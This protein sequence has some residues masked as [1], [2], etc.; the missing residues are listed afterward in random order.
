V[1]LFP[2]VIVYPKDR[3]VG[4]NGFKNLLCLSQKGMVISVKIIEREAFHICGYAIETNAEQNERDSSQ[5]Y[6][7]FFES[8]SVD[9]DYGMWNIG[10]GHGAAQNVV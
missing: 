8:D 6:K 5:L 3:S 4:K 9:G 7:D 2:Q 1:Y 10:L